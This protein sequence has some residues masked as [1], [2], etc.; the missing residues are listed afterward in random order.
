MKNILITGSNGFIGRNLADAIHNYDPNINILGYDI[1][2]S[3]DDLKNYCSVADF[4]FNLA[5]VM[6]PKDEKEFMEGN[7]GVLRQVLEE[8]VSANNYCP[9]MLSSSIQASRD[10]GYAQSKRAAEDLLFADAAVTGRKAVVFRFTNLFG[11]YKRPNTDSVVATFCYNIARNMPIKV[12][13]P[14]AEIT[15]CYIDDVC[16]EL[17]KTLNG[18]ESYVGRYA[19]VNPKYTIKIGDLAALIRY[20]ASNLDSILNDDFEYKIRSTYI[21][22]LP[23]NYKE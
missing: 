21:S 12:N 1:H 19:D 11:R 22:Y 13:D 15:F 20:I 14:S 4:I 23:V 9:V 2:S 16:T 6:R 5:G 7:C 8:T 10:G 3:H 18:N 17:I